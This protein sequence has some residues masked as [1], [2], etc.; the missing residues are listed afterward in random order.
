VYTFSLNFS[1]AALANQPDIERIDFHGWPSSAKRTWPSQL[2]REIATILA[3]NSV[4]IGIAG[5]AKS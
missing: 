5:I 2:D 3:D 4:G 1:G